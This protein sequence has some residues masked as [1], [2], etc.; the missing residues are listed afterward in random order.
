MLSLTFLTDTRHDF[1]YLLE[2]CVIPFNSLGWWF[3]KSGRG[4]SV[5]WF[6]NQMIICFFWI[7]FRI[8]TDAKLVFRTYINQEYIMTR[9][10]LV[11]QTY[12]IVVLATVIMLNIHW[13]SL[14][15]RSLKTWRQPHQDDNKDSKDSKNKKEN[16][17]TKK[18]K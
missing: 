12:T 1:Q 15:M 18:D 5:F 14:Q 9:L 2:E 6:L 17:E 11:E 8:L 13:F 7:V 4:D 16:K 3:K 10:T